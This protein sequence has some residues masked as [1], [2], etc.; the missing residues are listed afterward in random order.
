M[1]L[2]GLRHARIGLSRTARAW[3]GELSSAKEPGAAAA[4]A[5]MSFHLLYAVGAVTAFVSSQ[6]WRKG[7]ETQLMY[8][9]NVKLKSTGA[10]RR[11]AYVQTA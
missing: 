9:I 8:L 3:I 10:V 4:A 1:E 11:T 2:K 5:Q 6:G 7:P